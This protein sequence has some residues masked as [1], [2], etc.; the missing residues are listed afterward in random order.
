MKHPD[1]VVVFNV[2]LMNPHARALVPEKGARRF[3]VPGAV[4]YI[5]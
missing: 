4:P 1:P 5:I 3:D 2:G